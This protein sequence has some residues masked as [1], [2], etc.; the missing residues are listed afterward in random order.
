MR[1]HEQQPEPRPIGGRPDLRVDRCQHGLQRIGHPAV[2]QRRWREGA[3][4][5]ERSGRNRRTQH[6]SQ[7]D[8][9]VVQ[10][11]SETLHL[12]ARNERIPESRY[13]A[14][15]GQKLVQIDELAEAAVEIGIEEQ[16]DGRVQHAVDG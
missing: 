2:G 14:E 15:G 1:S 8:E 16:V 12:R 11:T 4:R 6:A 7:R 3:R 13:A 5:R 9:G 10:R